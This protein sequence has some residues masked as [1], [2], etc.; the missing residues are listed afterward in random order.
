MGRGGLSHGLEARIA[1]GLLLLTLFFSS[2]PYLLGYFSAPPDTRFIGTVYN[3]DDYCNYLSW[4]RQAM[5][6]RFFFHNLFTTD[7]QI[8]RE[9]NVFFWLLGRA[10]HYLRWSPQAIFQLARVL[11][12][13]ALLWLLWRLCRFCLSRSV[14]ARLT[15]FGFL[16]GSSGLGWITWRHWQDKSVGSAPVDAWQPEAFTFLSLYTSPLFVVST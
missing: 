4:L 11:G 6:G 7:P 9:F 16:C 15:A 12:G 14:A 13:A 10:A 8:D 3:I 5:D 1:L 2:L